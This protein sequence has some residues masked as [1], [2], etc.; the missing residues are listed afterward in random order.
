MT[1]LARQTPRN[2]PGI[3]L[4]TPPDAPL[5][6]GFA[7]EVA[8]D[9]HRSKDGR[10][11]L[12]GSPPRLIRLTTT[13]VRLLD[14][15]R[16]TVTDP[17][18]AVLARRLLDAGVVHPRPGLPPV[19]DTTVVIPIRDRA[20]QLDRLLTAVRAD[21]STSALPVLVVDD[22][23]R[24]PAALADVARRHGV[25]L[26]VHP[27]NLGPAAARNTGLR[28]ARTSYVAFC[29]SDVVPEA[30]WLAPLLAQFADPAVAL[31]AP[32]VVALPVSEP[33][34][35]DR[36]EKVHSPLDMGAKEGP[37]VPLSALSYVPGATVVVRRSAV[38][39]GFTEAM[40]VGED[41][42]LCIRLHQAGWR[43]RY[44]P[45]SRVGHRHRTDLRSWLAQRAAYG[46]SAADLALR[47][48]GQ[49]PPL[50]AAPWSLAACALLLRGRPAP[51]ALAAALTGAVAG[52]LRPR[53]AGADHPARA[54]ARLSLAALRGTAGQ[55]LRCATRHHWPVAVTAAALSRRA[56]YA[57]VAAAL[58]EGLVDHHR[59][60]TSLT[61]LAHTAIRRLDDLAYGWG[62]W[63]GAAR[64]R[65]T[66]PLRP[67]L[68]LPRPGRRARPRT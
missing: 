6:D 38:G 7:V 22:G 45:A 34:L 30:G 19:H 14:G 4:P 58:A 28:R 40:R 62:V 49:V 5:P 57:L 48:P 20:G 46:T 59:S 60:G 63:Q 52:R 36:Y 35:L 12:G 55:L 23:S 65:T 11:M 8:A 15:G 66:A 25:R 17:A 16:F 1:S 47:H 56:R 50:Y 53:M 3:G 26:L 27:Y 44:V 21:P 41:V 31:A 51:A 29:D 13:A 9:T 2:L 68:A 10:L 61:P 43:L 64:R 42:D 18:T 32:R 67:R 33:G 37:V 24:D 54:A 39:S